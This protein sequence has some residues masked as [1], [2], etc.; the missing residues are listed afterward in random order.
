MLKSRLRLGIGLRS[1]AQSLCRIQRTNPA[2]R[3]DNCPHG[4]EIEICG[5]INAYLVLRGFHICALQRDTLRQDPGIL[6]QQP[7]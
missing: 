6:R 5:F 7:Q 1:A 2:G 4:L 3:P